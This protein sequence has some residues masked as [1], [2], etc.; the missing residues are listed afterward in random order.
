[1]G[2]RDSVRRTRPTEKN[3][4]TSFVRVAEKASNGERSV[5]RGLWV[6]WQLQQFCQVGGDVL[7]QEG[8]EGGALG[9]WYSCW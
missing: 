4:V 3:V 7:C 2:R 1:M 6:W 8:V 9:C 5:L